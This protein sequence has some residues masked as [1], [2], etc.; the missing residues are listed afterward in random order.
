MYINEVMQYMI[1]SIPYCYIRNNRNFSRYDSRVRNSCPNYIKTY[2]DGILMQL[3]ASL[4]KL[5]F[6]YHLNPKQR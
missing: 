6:K 3:L 1:C 4:I 5:T 2:S